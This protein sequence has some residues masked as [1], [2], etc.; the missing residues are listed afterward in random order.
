MVRWKCL[1]CRKPLRVSDDMSVNVLFCSC[2]KASLEGSPEASACSMAER[3]L[4]EEEGLMLGG[5]RKRKPY[6]VTAISHSAPGLQYL[7]H[8]ALAFRAAS[9]LLP[10]PFR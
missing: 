1:E 10:P 9:S 7:C 5:Q 2:T 6:L 4:L 8:I 3:S